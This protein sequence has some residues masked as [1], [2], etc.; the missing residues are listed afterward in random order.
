MAAVKGNE[1]AHGKGTPTDCFVAQVKQLRHALHLRQVNTQTGHITMTGPTGLLP[2]QGN[3]R[4]GRFTAFFQIA[5]AFFTDQITPEGGN[6]HAV[7][8]FRRDTMSTQAG[9]KRTHSMS[10]Q[11]D[12]PED[13]DAGL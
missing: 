5:A 1:T 7:V 3:T 8:T 6:M 2:F 9:C 4:A 10:E 12:R 13:A 11:V